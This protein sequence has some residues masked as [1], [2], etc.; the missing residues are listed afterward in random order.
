MA[1][2]T[3]QA[4]R[5][6]AATLNDLFAERAT[7]T[8][9][10]TALRRKVAGAWED[11][12]WKAYRDA[13]RRIGLALIAQGVQPGHAVAILSE[14]RA[15][16]AF[17]DLGILGAGAVSVPIYHSCLTDEVE[18]ILRDSRA[19]V[20]FVENLD[21]WVKL[22]GKPEK[23]AHVTKVVLLDTADTEKTSGKDEGDGRAVAP[24]EG[25]E[26]VLSYDAF[27]EQADGVDA[28]RWEEASRAAGPDDVI[29]Y[30]Y[31]SGTTGNPKGVV[32]TH[33][34][35]VAEC[36]ALAAALEIADDEVTLAFLPLAH[37][38]ARVLHWM[39]LRA[40]YVAAFAEGIT[41]VV[42]NMGEVRPT[43]FAAVPRIYEKIH[44]GLL[45]KVN[46]NPPLK[47]RYV[48]WAIAQGVAREKAARGEGPGGLGLALKGALAGPALG[49]LKAGLTARTGGRLRYF[50]SGGAPLSP[51]I[52][53]FFATLGFSIYEGYGLT[54]TT[55]ATHLNKPGAH[56]IGTVGKA[57]TG[58]DC[59][60]APDGEIL[61]KGPVIMKGY[62]NRP[63][64]TA[65]VMQDGWFATGD[66]GVIDAEGFLKITDR[67]KDLIITAAGK[68]IAPQN[69]ENHV[70]TDRFVSQVALFGDKQRFCV[71]LVTIDEVEVRKAL[72]AEGIAPPAAYADLAAHPRTRALLEGSIAA[73]N[74]DLPT[75][76]QIKYF[77]LLPRELEVG[78]ELTP[79]LK[80]RRKVVATKYAALIE[81]LYASAGGGRD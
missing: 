49:K 56:K 6:Q 67:K 74:R 34:N 27:L 14:S 38:F 72:E 28:E 23:L 64:A 16:W 36:E 30:I 26:R 2:E 11:I 7:K 65:E 33:G 73:K 70:K 3:T 55:A 63:D 29:T 40:G 51:E 31:T 4:P 21:Q 43:F 25:D 9:Q 5:T 37:V 39:Q 10:R 81:K 47:R 13:A 48:H 22:A 41:K 18:F 75:Y 52:A 69:V 59:K 17:C 58:L 12:S 45:A 42:D 19:T 57:L 68:N 76:E 50:I 79:S 66:V 1:T 61:V 80:V 77:E 46:E 60:I 78:D 35:A 15:E 44:A 20:L 8:P 53:W 32:L 24:W 62:F 71:A 54:E